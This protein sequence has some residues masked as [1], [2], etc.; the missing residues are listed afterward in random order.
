MLEVA[1]LSP[2]EALRH[3]KDTFVIELR[4]IERRTLIDVGD[5]RVSASMPMSGTPMFGSVDIQR[6][7]VPGRYA[8]TADF[9]MAGPW[10]IAIEWDGPPDRAPSPS[11]EAF[12]RFNAHGGRVLT[13]SW[14][15]QRR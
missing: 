5:V 3:G 7:D 9:G 10:R 11:R 13:S 4:S 1:L 15:L 2:R 6:T 12:S 14:S 8:A